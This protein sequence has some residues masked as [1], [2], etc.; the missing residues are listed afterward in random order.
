[1]KSPVE[2]HIKKYIS[3]TES[4]I[5]LFQSLL[6]ELTV[7][8]KKYLVKPGIQLKHC[9]F[10]NKG[11][12]KAYYLD[13]KGNK[14]VIQFAIEN[15]WVSDF[16][17]FYHNLDIKL[18][19]EA[20]EDSTL[21]AINQENLEILFT[22]APAFERYFRILLTNAFI[23]QRKRVF[24]SLEKNTK[25]RY[26]EFCASYPNIENRVQNYHIANYLGVSAESLS[27]I[28]SSLKC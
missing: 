15:W 17:A 20:I 28:R 27:R 23:G 14:H 3:V 24:S 16:E 11:C 9:Y 1:M 13:K 19:I 25:E 18:Y 21:L 4:E 7:K 22:K 2:T 6:T 8:A 26:L 10:V 5:N 12:L